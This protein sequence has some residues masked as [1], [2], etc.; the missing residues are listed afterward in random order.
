MDWARLLFGC[1]GLGHDWRFKDGHV[2]CAWCHKK[3][4]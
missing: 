1:L 3:P 4:R 2:E